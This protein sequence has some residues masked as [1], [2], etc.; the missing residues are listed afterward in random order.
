MNGID[1]QLHHPEQIKELRLALALAEA[2]I[3]H[4]QLLLS[5]MT[6]E[7]NSQQCQLIHDFASPLQIISMSLESLLSKNSD[8]IFETMK[9][10]SDNMS[11]ILSKARK[12]K[13]QLSKK[14][15]TV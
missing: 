7:H 1:Q 6:L 10:A 12:M 5:E 13:V 2:K 11:T 3:T 4:Y 15:T 14:T 8:P 9:R